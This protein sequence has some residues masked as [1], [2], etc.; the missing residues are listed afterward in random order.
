MGHKSIAQQLWWNLL[1]KTSQLCYGF[2][3]LLLFL[4]CA[5]AEAPS[6]VAARYVRQDL[7]T[8]SAQAY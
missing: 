6:V 1:K 2:C 4:P 8:P 7:D 3:C 5:M